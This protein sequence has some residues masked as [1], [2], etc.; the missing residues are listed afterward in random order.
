MRIKYLITG[1]SSFWV[2][3]IFYSTITIGERQLEFGQLVS[4]D[5]NRSLLLAA[6][7]ILLI[8]GIF[9]LIRYRQMI[10]SLART[11]MSFLLFSVMLVV[12]LFNGITLW[13]QDA[14]LYT[15]LFAASVL[16]ILY[17]NW[18]FG[19]RFFWIAAVSIIAM[20]FSFIAIHGFPV[21]R[22]IGGIHPNH[23]GAFAL[24]ATFFA[25]RSGH[26]LRWILYLIALSFAIMISSRYAMIAI[27][28]IVFADY[29]ASIPRF[30]LRRAIGLVFLS[31]FFFLSI[32]FGHD[33]IAHWLALHD[34]A[35]GIDTGFTGR[36]DL[37]NN[38]A[39]QIL[40]RPFTGFG[41]RERGL[42]DGT[43]NGF[44][45]FALESGL[46]VMT[47]FFLAMIS[48]FREGITRL[49]SGTTHKR[50]IIVVL[51]SWVAWAFAAFFQPQL[52]NF[53]D[54]TGIMTI[55]LLTAHVKWIMSNETGKQT[56]D[57][58][59]RSNVYA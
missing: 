9:V 58:S 1:I 7:P 4:G 23:I 53:G 28:M 26:S 2:F 25:A 39:P 48:I 51:A 37:W 35:R 30:D 56:V 41:F 3:A 34:S 24:L 16:V 11:S 32:L 38:F 21:G 27:A 17:I 47:L 8:S 19:P 12:M 52:V 43:H 42:Y 59:P 55:F 50:D 14:I 22:W 45:N 36:A 13:N 29:V 57:H 6:G 31:A 15:A 54:A 33:L 18:I 44:L 10:V 5:G 40:D 49:R 46:I 20:L